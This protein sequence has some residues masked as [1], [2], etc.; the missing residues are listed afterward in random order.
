MNVAV[1]SHNLAEAMI[2]DAGHR[3]PDKCRGVGHG[4][5]STV[6]ASPPRP[7]IAYRGFEVEMVGRHF[8]PRITPFRRAEF[9]HPRTMEADVQGNV[10]ERIL[11]PWLDASGKPRYTR[12]MEQNGKCHYTHDLRWLDSETG[13]PVKPSTE[14]CKWLDERGLRS[15]EHYT[16][17]LAGEPGAAA[18]ASGHTGTTPYI[19]WL[20]AHGLKQRS[21]P[22]YT[23]WLDENGKPREQPQCPRWLDP[24]GHPDALSPSTRWLDPATGKHLI[25]L[26]LRLL[27]LVSPHNNTTRQLT[28]TSRHRLARAAHHPLRV[29]NV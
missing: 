3:S 6:P 5:A 8:R 20:P 18:P 16:G 17:M 10:K 27:A 24:Q 4:D 13:L 9:Q 7:A 26:R 1:L 21:T 22:K 12:W 2:S 28:T 19:P 15:S 23:S 29:H 25:Y 14:Q 11:P